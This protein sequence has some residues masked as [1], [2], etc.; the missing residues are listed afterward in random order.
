MFCAP[1][2]LQGNPAEGPFDWDTKV[3][4]F[5][6]GAPS[7]G[8][9]LTVF[10]GGLLAE[11]IGGNLLFGVGIVSSAMCSLFIPIA[12]GVSPYLVIFVRV[13]Q[14]CCQG[15][16]SPAFHNMANKW[17]PQNERNLLITAVIAGY[18]F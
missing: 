4:G 17:I 5:I 11:K 16:L 13:L 3:Q 1:V 6:L 9:F 14:G 2:F 18:I 12:A 15:P 10:G 7:L 8:N